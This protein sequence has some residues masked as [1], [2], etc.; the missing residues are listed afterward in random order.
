[1]EESTFTCRRFESQ[2]L[3]QVTVSM[4]HK[5]DESW[6]DA[7]KDFDSWHDTL[8]TMDNYD[9]WD[10]PP[11]TYGVVGINNEYTNEY[12]KSDFYIRERQT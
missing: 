5:A 8:E 12:I 1:M 9:E 11:T 2:E 10:E 4:S 6:F 7:Q 3:L